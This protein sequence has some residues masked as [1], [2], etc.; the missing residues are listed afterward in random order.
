M[1]LQEL[2]SELAAPDIIDTDNLVPIDLP[3]IISRQPKQQ[4]DTVALAI[5]AWKTVNPLF[6]SNLDRAITSY[7]NIPR[8]DWTSSFDKEIS[9]L[10]NTI[11]SIPS[12]LK[13][14]HHGVITL[15]NDQPWKACLQHIENQK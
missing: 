12:C 11:C 1:D 7:P 2:V 6:A 14:G 13:C 15:I 8:L 4:Q 3:Q 5:Q 9:N 10:K